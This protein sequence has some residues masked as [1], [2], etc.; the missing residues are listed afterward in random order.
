MAEV[1]SRPRTARLVHRFGF[2]LGLVF[3][4]RTR[5]D[6]NDPAQRA[7][8]WAH[9]QRERPIFIVG[10]WGGDSAGMSHMRWMMHIFRWRVAQER[11]FAHQYSGNLFS[12]CRVLFNEIDFGVLC[13]RLEDVRYELYCGNDTWVE[14]SVDSN[15]LFA[16]V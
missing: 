2:T 10:S 12:E 13:R 7:K 1:F 14:A 9:L 16:G 8:M 3:D 5:W 6:L 15:W 11:F 4:L